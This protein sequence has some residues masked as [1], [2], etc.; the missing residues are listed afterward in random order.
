MSNKFSYD[1]GKLHHH[2]KFCFTDFFRGS[3][4]S[5]T[6]EDGDGMAT[7]KERPTPQE[8]ED[9]D[10][11]VNKMIIIRAVLLILILMLIVVLCRC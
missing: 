8:M 2:E 5:Y 1:D 11:M 9:M 3:L 4:P 10:T 7:P 6:R